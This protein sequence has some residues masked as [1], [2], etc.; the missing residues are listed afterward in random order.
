MC[1]GKK[2]LI[3]IVATFCNV[4][5]NWV[6]TGL[7][8]QIHSFSRDEPPFLKKYWGGGGKRLPVVKAAESVSLSN[9]C[10]WVFL[11]Y[12][13]LHMTKLSLGVKLIP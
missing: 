2:V 11:C 1:M 5:T 6:A 8:D 10:M 12:K 7:H 3:V 4:T 13:K 9:Y